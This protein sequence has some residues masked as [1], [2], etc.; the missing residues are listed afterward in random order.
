MPIAV[1]FTSDRAIMH[2]LDDVIHENYALDILVNAPVSYMPQGPF[3][4]FWE[5]GPEAWDE[6][7][8]LLRPQYVACVYGAQ[9]MANLKRG[10]IVNVGSFQGLSRSEM[11]GNR[12]STGRN[13]LIS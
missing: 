2:T 6:L 11:H 9:L 12:R 13:H 3:K 1:D 5:R 8:Q 10:L 4:P 7:N